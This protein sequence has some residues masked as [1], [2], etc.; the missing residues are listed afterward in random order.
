MFKKARIFILIFILILVAAVQWKTR[1]QLVEWDNSVW[2]VIYP[3]AA[4]NSPNTLDYIESLTIEQLA[5]IEAFI[6]DEADHYGIATEQPIKVSLA[7]PIN[8]MPPKPPENG[9]LLQVMLWSLQLRYWAWNNEDKSLAGD[10]SLFVLYHD[11]ALMPM[12]PHS[13]GLEKGHIGL[14]HA[15][16]SKNMTQSNSVI[17]THELLHT[18]GATDKYDLHT[19]LPIFPEGYA[20]PELEPLYPQQ[21][22][23]IMG[24]RI[25]VS[26]NE[27][28][29]PEHLNQTLI[30][31]LTA[32]EIGW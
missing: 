12:V 13:L 19:S 3:I 2:T 28:D 23:E 6:K 18:L 27:A 10:I 30:G 26:S 1:S 11:P 21:T 9:S 8:Q 4:D 16:A 5:A 15:F 32:Q 7:I 20:D 31:R 14:I 17:I 24:G 29:I 25:P 22:A